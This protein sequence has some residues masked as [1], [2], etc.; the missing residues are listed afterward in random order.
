ML[1]E[2]SPY[3]SAEE[4]EADRPPGSTIGIDMT[5]VLGLIRSLCRR[6]SGGNLVERP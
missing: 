1:S 2:R 3:V 6:G 4:V 5:S